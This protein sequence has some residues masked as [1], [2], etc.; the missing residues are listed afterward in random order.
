[1]PLVIARLAP[2]E[3]RADIP[4]CESCAY[5]NT[6]ASGPSPRRV[7]EAVCDA[8]RRHEFDL[9]D[10]GHYETA[11]EL[12]DAAREALAAHLGCSPADIALTASTGDGISR[13]A[14]ALDWEAGD[15]VVRTDLEHPSG[16]LPWRRLTDVGV[17]VDTLSCPHG[18]LPMEAYHDAVAD[19]DLVCFSSESWFHGTRLPVE[20]AVDIAHDA[21]ALV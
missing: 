17:E 10:A 11:T 16:V 21:G 12:K 2:E 14:N 20:A 18:R 13:V 9:R 5:L 8:Q 7:V 15:R 19:A 4:A 1:M 6:G 3:L